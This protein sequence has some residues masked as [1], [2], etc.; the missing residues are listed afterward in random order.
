M[1]NCLTC[2][3]EPEWKRNCQDVIG[4]EGF[5]IGQEVIEEATDCKV[6]VFNKLSSLMPDH[7]FIDS[8]GLIKVDGKVYVDDALSSEIT[9]C[10][11]W[12]EKETNA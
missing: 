10:P 7:Y 11:A 4:V 6:D 2:K 9:N 12:Q 5:V 8:F 1:K 3:W